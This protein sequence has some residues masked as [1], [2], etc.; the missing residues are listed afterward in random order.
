MKQRFTISKAAH[1]LD[2]SERWLRET[3]KKGKIPV[4]RRDLN[5]W[6]IYTEEDIEHIKA[7]LIPE[8]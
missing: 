7:L 1:E 4:A 5:G 3:E 6:R 8:N 2:C